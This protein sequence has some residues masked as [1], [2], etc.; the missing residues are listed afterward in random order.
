MCKMM[1]KIPVDLMVV[2]KARADQ[3]N[4]LVSE[5]VRSALEAYL[6]DDTEEDDEEE[7]DETEDV[8]EEEEP[9]EEGAEKKKDEDK[10]EY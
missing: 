8:E 7:D 6:F 3:D 9:E 1:S 5:V 10:D 4:I 2:L